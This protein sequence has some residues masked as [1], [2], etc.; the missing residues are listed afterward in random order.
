MSLLPWKRLDRGRLF[1]VECECGGIFQIPFDPEEVD[2]HPDRQ[3]LVPLEGTCPGCGLKV[4]EIEP[5]ADP[6]SSSGDRSR[7]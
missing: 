4:E 2:Y 5:F 1:E 7:A 6:S 3:L